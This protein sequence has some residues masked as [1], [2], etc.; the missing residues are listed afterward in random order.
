MTTENASIEATVWALRAFYVVGDV[1]KFEIT[2]QDL[3]TLLDQY[4]LNEESSIT[5]LTLVL[6]VLCECQP[7]SERLE[8]LKEV[9][10]KK[11]YYSK[12]GTILYWPTINKEKGSTIYTVLSVIS[13]MN[14][15][16][17]NKE[18][19]Q[20]VNCL[21]DCGKWIL[22]AEWDNV[23]EIISRPISIAKEDR[24]VY[25]HYTAPWGIIAL[26]KLGYDKEEKRIATEIKNILESERSGFWFWNNESN[27]PIWAI[28]NA[29]CAIE[30]FVLGDIKL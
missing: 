23:E 7:D 11:A 19:E 8:K 16:R 12:N 2:L 14:Y 5:T 4:Q 10:I 17:I 20:M 3:Y 21:H 13:L 28:Y 24:L 29:I 18:E 6:D 22:K 25:Q 30:E 27:F 1:S 26:L 15:A 9:I